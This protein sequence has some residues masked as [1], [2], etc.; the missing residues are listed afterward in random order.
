VIL[1]VVP[2]LAGSAGVVV[3]L[4][5]QGLDRAE[6][7]TSL[8]GVFV[9]VVVGVGGLTLGWLAWRQKPGVGSVSPMRVSRT[10]NAVAAGP[11]STAVSGAIGTAP[12]VVADR[13]GDATAKDGGH[14]VTGADRGGLRPVRSDEAE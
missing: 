1:A 10:G 6:K 4:A 14:A 9:S 8:V 12:G 13:T 11:G 3:L 7:W 5:G 2:A